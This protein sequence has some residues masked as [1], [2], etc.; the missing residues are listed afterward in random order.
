MILYVKN[1]YPYVLNCEV[2]SNAQKLRCIESK[3]LRHLNDICKKKS[4][5]KKKKKIHIG[6][7]KPSCELKKSK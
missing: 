3:F 4:F 6:R 7:A 2:K 1:E 5:E